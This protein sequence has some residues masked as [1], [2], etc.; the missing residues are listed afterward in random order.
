[1]RLIGFVGKTLS[2]IMSLVFQFLG[3]VFRLLVSVVKGLGIR[4][5]VVAKFFA[6]TTMTGGGLGLLSFIA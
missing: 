5:L 6:A 4:N 1:M 3:H 2:M